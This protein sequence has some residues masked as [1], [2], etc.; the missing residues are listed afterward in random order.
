MNCF[1]TIFSQIE[2]EKD[3]FK[4][5]NHSEICDELLKFVLAI[6]IEFREGRIS[7]DNG[8]GINKSITKTDQEMSAFIRNLSLK[9]NSNLQTEHLNSYKDSFLEK[10]YPNSQ[11]KYFSSVF[12]YIM[13]EYLD[14]TELISELKEIDRKALKP[15]YQ[16]YNKLFSNG[17]YGLL[18]FDD[19]LLKA[20]FEKIT[21]FVKKVTLKNSTNIQTSIFTLNHT[22]N[23]GLTWWN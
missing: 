21:N 14:K 20:D 8:N 2:I 1:H 5:L 10:Y 11:Y 23:M 13:S 15:A 4:N 19:N 18:Q 3:N 12:K 16:L 9:N 22:Q 6:S 17:P 7:F